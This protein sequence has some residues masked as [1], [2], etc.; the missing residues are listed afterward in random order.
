MNIFKRYKTILIVIAL[1]IIGFVVYSMFFSG[2][3]DV[4]LLEQT[5]VGGGATGGEILALL[6]TLRG[7][8]FNTGVLDSTL[9]RSL[10]DF[11]VELTPEPVGRPN[12]F[13]PVGVD[14]VQPEI[15]QGE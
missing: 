13:A 7:I 14:S 4:A 9:F 15:P 3:D 11:G 12:P 2:E 10:V 6:D 1:I 8:D 5:P